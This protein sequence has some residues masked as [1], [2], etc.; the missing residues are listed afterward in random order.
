MASHNVLLQP[1]L[2]SSSCRQYCY[3]RFCFAF[4]FDWRIG[5][6]ET[7]T[8]FVPNRH[9]TVVL[10]TFSVESMLHRVTRGALTIFTLNDPEAVHFRACSFSHSSGTLSHSSKHTG[11]RV[12]LESCSCPSRSIGPAD[13]WTLH[14][15]WPNGF[16]II[17]FRMLKLIF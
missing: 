1:S 13:E 7:R 6:A 5:S 10:S 16:V 12:Y 15:L 2:E 9:T 8:N 4:A 11:S 3:C 17:F 14:G